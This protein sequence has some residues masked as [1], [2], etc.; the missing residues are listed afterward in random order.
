[1]KLELFVLQY[2]R[3]CHLDFQSISKS[4]LDLICTIYLLSFADRIQSLH[5]SD[6]D[7][8]P[9]QITLFLSYSFQFDQFLHFKNSHFILSSLPDTSNFS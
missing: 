8:T 2:C 5:L 1:M 7:Q 6:D 4:D 9:E 3:Q